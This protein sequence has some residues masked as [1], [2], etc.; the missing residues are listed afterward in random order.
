ML[1][2]SPLL[3][4]LS[5]ENKDVSGGKEEEAKAEREEE[6][7]WGVHMEDVPSSGGG[8]FA[9]WGGWMVRSLSQWGS[10]AMDHVNREVEE[11]LVKVGNCVRDVVRTSPS[12]FPNARDHHRRDWPGGLRDEI[13]VRR[14]LEGS[15]MEK[16]AESAFIP[17]TSLLSWNQS[18]PVLS[19]SVL[20]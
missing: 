20:I 19:W 9:P 13:D 6:G 2:E 4:T 11:T 12:Y 18:L 10:W 16:G 5:V 15:G 7:F 1:E 8:N 14:A 3:E 17:H